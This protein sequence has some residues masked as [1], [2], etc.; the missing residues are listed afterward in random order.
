MKGLAL[1]HPEHLDVAPGGVAGDREFFLVD[2]A[3][4]LISCTEIGELMTV[5]ASYDAR[6]RRLT[7]HGARRRAALG[8]RR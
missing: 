3:G 2:A 5:S 4:E 8:D 1:H 7:V 6:T